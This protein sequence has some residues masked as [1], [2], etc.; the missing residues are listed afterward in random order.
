MFKALHTADFHLGSNFSGAK[1]GSEKLKNCQKTAFFDMVNYAKNHEIEFFIISGDLFD[2]KHSILQNCNF[3]FQIMQNCPEIKFMICAGNHDPLSYD[4]FYEKARSLKNVFIFEKELTVFEFENVLF[5]G[6]SQLFPGDNSS[7]FKD[8]KIK[9]CNKPVIA[10]LHGDIDKNGNY[11][12]FSTD[13]L[14]N[15]NIDYAAFGHIH[16]K[17]EIKSAGKC[18]YAYCGCPYSRGFDE[19][20]DTGFYVIDNINS[21]LKIDFVKTDF[22]KFNEM[23]IDISNCLENAEVLNLINEKISFIPENEILRIVLCGEVSIQSDISAEAI[24]EYLNN[25]SI[26]MIKDKTKIK[27]DFEKYK[28]EAS[29]KGEFIRNMLLKLDSVNDEKEKELILLSLKYG[30]KSFN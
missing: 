23:E 9:D 7:A 13:D 19:V 6:V 17:S 30:L 20:Y 3:I 22:I 15:S 18:Y 10:V 28:D 4:L 16:K 1:C 26:A 2:N 5:C 14:Q 11:L 24:F 12:N 8:I 25:D 29:L 27:M 21:T